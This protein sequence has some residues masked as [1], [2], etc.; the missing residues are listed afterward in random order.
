MAGTKKQVLNLSIYKGERKIQGEMS[1]LIKSKKRKIAK[2]SKAFSVL[3]KNIINFC[4]KKF[5][6]IHSLVFSLRGRVGRN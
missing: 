5:S 1:R 3:S 2:Q 6:F 4:Y